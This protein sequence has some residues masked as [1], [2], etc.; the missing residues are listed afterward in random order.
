[1]ANTL[2]FDGNHLFVNLSSDKSLEYFPA[3]TPISF[4]NVLTNPIKFADDCYELAAAEIIYEEKELPKA[5]HVADKQ[6][7]FGL[8]PTTNNLISTSKLTR[9]SIQYPK[10][11]T[12]FKEWRRTLQS[13][14]NDTL[15]TGVATAGM[16]FF[17]IQG[18]IDPKTVIGVNDSSKKYSV[19]I[20]P[21][22]YSTVLGF[23]NK[24]EFQHGT[25]TSQSIQSREFFDKI[26]LNDVLHFRLQWSERE[27][28]EVE[29]PSEYN[30]EL[31][32]L[33][34]AEKLLEQ[35]YKIKMPFDPKSTK[36]TVEI[37]DTTLS[38]KL[39]ST[40][41]EVLGL[42]PDFEFNKPK[43]VI[44]VGESR[45]RWLEKTTGYYPSQQ[46]YI[47]CSI[48]DSKYYGLDQRPGPDSIS[49]L[50]T[51]PRKMIKGA[52]HHVFNPLYFHPLKYTEVQNISVQLTGEHLKPIT[53]AASP[54]VVVLQF[55][56]KI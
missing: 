36:L 56:R 41:N 13:V 39:P 45:K 42:E 3:N 27:L 51:F 16:S 11:T 35:G 48:A 31:L 7:Y 34:C 29:E 21:A 49:V 37:D 32:L 19:Q 46:V 23:G 4:T 25:H 22:Y 54:T 15:K 38:F 52:Q 12:N 28:I 9:R 44:N 1:M 2:H 30:L 50:R 5:P 17:Y 26:P 10:T 33:N 40:V 53:F 14:I 24:N 43:T 20:T 47:H 55:Q 8:D 18:E 6:L